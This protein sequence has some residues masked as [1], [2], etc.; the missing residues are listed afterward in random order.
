MTDPVVADAGVAVAWVLAEHYRPV[1]Q[2]L[3]RHAPQE[4]ALELAARFRLRASYDAQ[5]LALAQLRGC[6]LWTADERLYNSVQAEL[7]RVRWLGDPA[8][9]DALLGPGGFP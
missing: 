9:V 3:A 2:A 4:Q 6:P 7:P 1:A 8:A 5:Y